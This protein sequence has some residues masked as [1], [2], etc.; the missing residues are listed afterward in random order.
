MAY[1]PTIAIGVPFFKSS[2]ISINPNNVNLTKFYNALV[3]DLQTSKVRV[4]VLGDS[5]TGRYNATLPLTQGFDVL[6]RDKYNAKFGVS[7]NGDGFYPLYKRLTGI[8]TQI[9]SYWILT[10][11][12][13]VVGSEPNGPHG[14]QRFITG[15]NTC[16]ITVNG[17]YFSFFHI[18]S[19]F[20]TNTAGQRAKYSVD[21]GAAVEFNSLNATYQQATINVDM[22]TNATHTIV[23]TAPPSAFFCPWGIE[24]TTKQTGLV[25]WNVGLS[26]TKIAEF[27]SGDTNGWIS[28]AAPKLVI[29]PVNTNDA[30]GGTSAASFETSMNLIA[31]QVNINGNLY[32][33]GQNL[34]S[35]FDVYQQGTLYPKQQS[36][37]T[38]KGAALINIPDFAGWTTLAIQN[39]SGNCTD[40][41]HPTTQGMVGYSDIIFSQLPY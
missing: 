14:C 10:N 29:M 13:I 15:S 27:K 24:I 32:I 31:D 12:G 8:T 3:D 38:A 2:G 39:S 30:A 6:L 25:F 28:A 18:L 37:A 9:D 17:R 16:T 41:V 11:N 21:G 4:A 22:G 34:R 35:G 40:G 7:Q 36:V 23:F 33:V 5:I 19:S 1:F 26:G 20:G